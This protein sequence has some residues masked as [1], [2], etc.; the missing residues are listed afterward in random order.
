MTALLKER[1]QVSLPGELANALHSGMVLFFNGDQLRLRNDAVLYHP[2]AHFSQA[3]KFLLELESLRT[4]VSLVTAR[5]GMS[6]R[7]GNLGDMHQLRDMILARDFHSGRVGFEQ[8]GIV[9]AADL[10]EIVAALTLRL[11]ARI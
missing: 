9:P 3:V 10:I 2:L 8:R 4:L 7:L 5:R 1:S 6:L 11:W